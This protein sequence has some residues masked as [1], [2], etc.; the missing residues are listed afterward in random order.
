[1]ISRIDS[2]KLVLTITL[3]LSGTFLK[4]PATSTPGMDLRDW[5]H[6]PPNLAIWAVKRPFTND[7][8]QIFWILNPSPLVSTKSMQT[9]FLWSEFGKPPSLPLRAD[10]LCAWPPFPRDS[11]R[12]RMRSWKRG[13]LALC[14][15]SH[16]P[17]FPFGVMM[18]FIAIAHA[19]LL[20][21][22]DRLWT[23][24]TYN[25]FARFH[26]SS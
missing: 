8:S 17:S 11:L 25:F 12:M 23:R 20:R 4:I 14:L 22:S 21:C 19:Y 5:L 6:Y 18:P 10:V 2:S 26:E 24:S 9:P 15:I 7:V 16:D 3:F 13:S 1:M